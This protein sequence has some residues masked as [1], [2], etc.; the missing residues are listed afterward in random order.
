[1]KESAILEQRIDGEAS[2]S[3]KDRYQ[4]MT[5]SVMFLMVETRPDIAFATSIASRFAKNPGH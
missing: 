3:E 4:D 1:M 5:D 2:S